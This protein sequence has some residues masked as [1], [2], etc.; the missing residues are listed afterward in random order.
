MEEKKYLD[1]AGVSALAERI[2]GKARIFNGTK[3]AWDALSV[4]ERKKYDNFSFT[5]YDAPSSGDNIFYIE[6]N[7]V[8]DASGWFAFNVD[9][10]KNSILAV[11]ETTSSTTGPWYCFE[12]FSAHGKFYIRP[13]APTAHDTNIATGTSIPVRVTCLREA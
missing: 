9:S 13:Y 12:W 8:V 6:G 5:D 4:D 1:D 7:L 3:S 10:L 2:K 11:R